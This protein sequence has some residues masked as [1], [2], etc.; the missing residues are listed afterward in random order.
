MSSLTPN[1]SLII[2]DA[3]DPV[4]QVRNDYAT[5]L[6]IIDGMGGGHTI[7]DENGTDMPS[8]GKLQFTGGVQV[9]DDNV[10]GVTVVNV[11]GGNGL[12][13]DA[14]IYSEE[15]KLVGV[16][17]DG[18]PLY[19]KS[20]KATITSG[21][22]WIDTGLD[23]GDEIVLSEG[24][25]HQNNGIILT[26]ASGDSSANAG[27][28]TF[29]VG[30]V[31]P[32]KWA[33]L[34]RT[35]NNDARG[36]LTLTLYYTKGSDVAGSGGFQAYGFTPIIYSD[37]ERVIG[38]WRDNKPLYKKTWYFN[39]T[40]VI[41][42]NTWTSLGISAGDIE[43]VVMK[44][45]VD[46]EGRSNTVNYCGVRN[47]YISAY[48]NLATNIQ[49]LTLYYTKTTDVAGSGDYNTLGVP[50]VHYSTDEQVIGTY[51][52]KPLYQKTW[53]FGS[54]LVVSYNSWTNTIIKLSDYAIKSVISAVGNNATGGACWNS[55]D[56][57][58][59]VSSYV[60]LLC[61]RN[62]NSTIGVRYLTLQYTKTTD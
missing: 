34:F 54:N 1:H 61:N 28:N 29:N 2:P 23:S 33:C 16:W 50:T 6:N 40:I 39:S 38:V 17:T 27:I 5:N 55:V 36:A 18:K 7:V 57:S 19:K 21:T 8:E 52:G 42:A 20:Y 37:T 62:G 9:S 46:D 59:E 47:S 30:V 45:T 11:S 14:S 49:V 56:V 41:N 25:L 15:E 48:S 44:E 13:L 10:N 4:Q 12:I 43:N 31:T 32:D 24:T 60:A 26:L 58:T 35:N 3:T 51:F 53:D 22:Q